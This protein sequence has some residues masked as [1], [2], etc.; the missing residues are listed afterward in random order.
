MTLKTSK[1][2]ESSAWHHRN[3]L[4]NNY[5]KTENS[6]SSVIMFNICT[7]FLVIEMQPL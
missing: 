6:Y 2:A 1:D 3:K 4:Q 7:V 5:I